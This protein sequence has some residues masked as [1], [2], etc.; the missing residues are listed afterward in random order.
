MKKKDKKIWNEIS[1]SNLNSTI[2]KMLYY[3]L[4]CFVSNLTNLWFYFNATQ[5]KLIQIKNVIKKRKKMF[6]TKWGDTMRDFKKNI[7]KKREKKKC[8]IS[9]RLLRKKSAGKS[10]EI[11]HMK[12]KEREKDVRKKREKGKFVKV[13]ATILF[14]SLCF[15]F[16]LIKHMFCCWFNFFFWWLW[17]WI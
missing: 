11:A 2:F 1:D 6:D 9:L 12:V 10:F 16:L 13:R 3:L 17:W 5:I 8:G 7:W 14:C 4:L 15:F